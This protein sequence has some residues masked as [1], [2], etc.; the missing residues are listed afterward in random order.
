[1]EMNTKK[2]YEEFD[3]TNDLREVPIKKYVLSVSMACN[4]STAA[5]SNAMG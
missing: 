2:D 5:Y 1:M 4:V 3:V